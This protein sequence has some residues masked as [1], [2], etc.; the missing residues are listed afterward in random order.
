MCVITSL[1]CVL[2]CSG[3]AANGNVYGN[4]TDDQSRVTASDDSYNITL[5][6]ATADRTTG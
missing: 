5:P 2:V 4:S 3:L 6:F 1:L